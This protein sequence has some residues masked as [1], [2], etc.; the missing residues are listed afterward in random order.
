M[1]HQLTQLEISRLE[2]FKFKAYGKQFNILIKEVSLEY[3]M[4]EGKYRVDCFLHLHPTCK[5]YEELNGALIIEVTDTHKTSRKKATDLRKENYLV[6]EINIS[7]R[8]T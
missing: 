4:I 8:K 3:S 1:P 6:V 2:S 7:G 5:H